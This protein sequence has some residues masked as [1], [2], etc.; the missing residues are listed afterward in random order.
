MAEM[1]LEQIYAAL[2]ARSWEKASRLCSMR[3]VRN[4]QVARALKA[5][6]LQRMGES[7]EAVQICRD[8]AAYVPTEEAILS[9]MALVLNATGNTREVTAMYEAA[10]KT[11]AGARRQ[12]PSAACAAPL[13]R[14]AQPRTAPC[15]ACSSATSRSSAGRRRS[16]SP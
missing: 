6:A 9:P 3:E 12:R 15:A 2:E 13:S 14:P 4:L 10:V 5:H 8:L 7:T 16:A 1:L 11:G